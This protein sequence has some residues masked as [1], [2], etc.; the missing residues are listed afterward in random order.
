MK[1]KLSFEFGWFKGEDFCLFH[2]DILNF[3][4]NENFIQLFKIKI[5]KFIIGFD[6]ER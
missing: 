6:L 4:D 2:I 3:L 5:L 1:F